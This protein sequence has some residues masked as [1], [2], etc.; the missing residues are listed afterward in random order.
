MM[1]VTIRRA[2]LCVLL[3]AGAA[4]PAHADNRAAAREA[5]RDGTRLYE[6][7]EF[8][9]ALDSFKRAYLNYADPSLLFNLGQCYRQLGDK[10]EAL[11]SYR[12]FLNK[13]PDAPN[14]AEVERVI[15]N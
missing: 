8:Q 10:P 6:I 2:L 9:K 7:G 5:F 4:A 11:R 3:L 12:Q 15:A 1:P 14:R 13:V